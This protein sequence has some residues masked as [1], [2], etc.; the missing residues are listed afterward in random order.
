MFDD[1]PEEPYS[2]WD[3]PDFQKPTGWY[4]FV[5]PPRPRPQ[6]CPRT[7]PPE[8]RVGSQAEEHRPGKLTDAPPAGCCTPDIS[9]E[10]S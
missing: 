4:P 10:R 8:S 3:D 9:R 6:P 2:V 7:Q 5:L 1:P